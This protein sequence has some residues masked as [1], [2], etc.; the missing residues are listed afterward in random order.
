MNVRPVVSRRDLAR[1]IELPYALHRGDPSWVP[2]LRLT[3][4]A[5]FSRKNPFFE[6]ATMQLFLAEDRGRTVGRVAA[7]DDRLHNDTHGDNLAFF[8]F[9]EAL[10]ETSALALLAAVE[11]WARAR[12]R[13]AVRGPA[14]PSMNDGSGF[15]IDAFGT[16][17]YV[18]MP[19]NPP[20]YPRYLARAGY[21]KV[22]DLYAW[23]FDHHSAAVS[24]LERLAARV[25]RR[26]PVRVRPVDL[27]RF[28]AELAIVERLYNGAWEENWGFVRYTEAEFRALAREL[29]LIIDPEIAVFAELAGEPVG[30]ALAL[31]DINQVL[32]KMNGRIVPFGFVHLLRR[33]QLIDQAR[34]PILGVVKE[35]RHKGFELVLIHEIIRRSR[36][37]GYRRGECSWI[38]EDNEAMNK[39]IAAAGAER[40][41]TYRLFQKAL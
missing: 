38:L 9:F 16:P 14:N 22:K 13:A 25:Q 37:R 39:G 32:K 18:M 28:E 24:R 41:K 12:G 40:Y 36:A 8:G 15:Q 4:R 31:P 27:K 17:P 23:L 5:R 11:A 29:R 10:D 30:L 19:W 33:R 35:H 20:A 21:T 6:H 34:L 7:I 3:E 2:P 26:Y 1:F